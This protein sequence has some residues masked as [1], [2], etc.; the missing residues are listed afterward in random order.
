MPSKCWPKNNELKGIFDSNC[1]LWIFFV[2]WY[3][4]YIF[5]LLFLCFLSVCVCLL[6]LFVYFFFACLFDFF[7]YKKR[8]GSLRGSWCWGGGEG[9]EKSWGRGKHVWTIVY[10]KSLFN[11]TDTPTK[12]SVATLS[13]MTIVMWGWGSSLSIKKHCSIHGEFTHKRIDH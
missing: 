12:I 6:F 3:S 2:L 1:L 13:V 11:K 5:W 7:F 8:K 9:S 10:G 4:V